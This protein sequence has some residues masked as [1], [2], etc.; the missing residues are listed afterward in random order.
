MV[1]DFVGV[2]VGLRLGVVVGAL[3]GD[4]L[5]P[6]VGFDVGVL[7][8]KFIETN[9]KIK[10]SLHT[11]M[12]CLLVALRA[13]LLELWKVNPLAVT[14]ELIK[15][16]IHQVYSKVIQTSCRI[17]RGYRRISCWMFTW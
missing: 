12:G 1:G 2:R 11:M 6:E 9:V 13:L 8:I 16:N 7:K 5:G 15:I 14:W 10:N 4:K 3:D 17:S